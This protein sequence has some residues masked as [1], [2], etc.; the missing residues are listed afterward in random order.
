I[1]AAETEVKSAKDAKSPA[2]K[3]PASLVPPDEK[4][5]QRYSPHHEFPISSASSLFLHVLTLGLLALF[6]IILKD[7]FFNDKGPE[8]D[9]IIVAG[10]GGRPDGVEAPTTG[11]NTSQEAVPK[12]QDTAKLERP[13]TTPTESLKP[14]EATPDKLLPPTTEPTGRLIEEDLGQKQ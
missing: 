4:F 2:T 11:F 8:V 13:S 9:G 7:A 10:G 6:G 14:L 5:W 1:M 12:A 3:K